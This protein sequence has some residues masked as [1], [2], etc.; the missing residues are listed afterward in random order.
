[1]KTLFAAFLSLLIAVSASGCAK[2]KPMIDM[3]TYRSNEYEAYKF[4]LENVTPGMMRE[5]VEKMAAR[6][7]LI[8]SVTPSHARVVYEF[9]GTADPTSGVYSRLTITIDKMNNQVL[10]IE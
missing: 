8:S 7:P 4:M 6:R 9:E 2:K 10:K 1:M 3:V 5:D